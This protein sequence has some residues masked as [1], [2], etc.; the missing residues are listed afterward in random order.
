M[1]KQLSIVC[2][3]ESIYMEFES[4]Y[5]SLIIP[6]KGDVVVINK[7]NYIVDVIIHKFIEA[8]H[9]EASDVHR[10]IVIVKPYQDIENVEEL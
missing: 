1:S 6:Q 8:P 4:R 7:Q 9:R 10:V 2:E 3:G 5:D